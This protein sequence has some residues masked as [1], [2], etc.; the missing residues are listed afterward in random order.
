MP[1]T[2]YIR[3]AVLIEHRLVTDKRTEDT[4]LLTLSF[5]REVNLQFPGRGLTAVTTR[6]TDHER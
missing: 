3:S 6:L 4:G 2:S 5:T 1:K